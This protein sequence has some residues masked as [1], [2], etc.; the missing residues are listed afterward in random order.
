M[1]YQEQSNHDNSHPKRFYLAE[2]PFENT[3]RLR[4]KVSV[5]VQPKYTPLCGVQLGRN[6]YTPCSI[7][8]DYHDQTIDFD[9][10]YLKLKAVPYDAVWVLADVK[11]KF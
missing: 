8:A 9:S 1:M 6:P 2:L 7:K 4:G 10:K 11:Y 3:R 5:T